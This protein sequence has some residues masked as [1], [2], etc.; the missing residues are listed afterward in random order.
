MQ[1]RRGALPL[2]D[3]PQILVILLLAA[4]AVQPKT[5]RMC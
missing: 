1:T 3:E 2:F 5:W 4:D